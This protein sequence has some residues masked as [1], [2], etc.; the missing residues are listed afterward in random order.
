M[1]LNLHLKQGNLPKS[2]FCLR[3]KS[4]LR[5]KNLR[6]TS[7]I[8]SL[9]KQ[10]SSKSCTTPIFKPLSPL[11]SPLTS[12]ITSPISSPLTTVSRVEK[13][14]LPQ[15]FINKI[16]NK[17]IKLSHENPEATKKLLGKKFEEILKQTEDEESLLSNY[18]SALLPKNYVKNRYSN[19]LPFERTRVHLKTFE[20]SDFINANWVDGL[21]ENTGKA[22]IATQGPTDQTLPEFWLMVWETN[23]FI[24]VMLTKEVELGRPKCFQ[25]WPSEKNSLLNA[26]QIKIEYESERTIDSHLTERKFV[27]TNTQ[28]N[29]KRNVIQFQYTEWPDHGI[30]SSRELFLKLVQTAEDLNSKESPL[31]VHCSAGI[32]RTGTFCTVHSN[33]I[34]MKNEIQQK[35]NPSFDIF[36]TVLNFRK[37]RAGMVQTPEQFIFCYLAL[38]EI[39]NNLT[40]EV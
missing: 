23:V 39:Y 34:K 40:K 15:E 35:K 13:R 19:V 12:P 30:P 3:I 2:F 36:Q 28:T 10:I 33:W 25:Y 8:K 18:T 11:S 21:S 29:E 20:G 14:S 16:D 27:V 6:M 4:S 17:R 38:Q 7:R 1:A 24:I 31:L 9:T 37:Q 22:Y 32:G 5:Q 26:G